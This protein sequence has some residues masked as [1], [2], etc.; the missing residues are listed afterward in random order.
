VGNTPGI[1]G[2]AYAIEEGNLLA[3][4]LEGI[5]ELSVDGGSV[6]IIDERLSDGVIVARV[7]EDDYRAFSLYCTHRGVE[8][9]Y[10]PEKGRLVCASAGS[11]AFTLTGERV[12]GPAESDLAVYPATL[13]GNRL[14][15]T[16]TAL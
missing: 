11:S 9:E 6:K 7:G 1:A 3:L 4:N 14:A 10:R 12:K 13:D 8:L 15:I 5:P 16:V 2:D